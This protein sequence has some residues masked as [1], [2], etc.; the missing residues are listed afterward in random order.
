MSSAFDDLLFSFRVNP[1]ASD[2][3]D[4]DFDEFMQKRLAEFMSIRDKYDEYY[5]DHGSQPPIRMLH[6]SEALSVLESVTSGDGGDHSGEASESARLLAAKLRIIDPGL[7]RDVP[8]NIPM[9]MASSFDDTFA[10][11]S[12]ALVHDL[13]AVH[14]ALYS[15]KST[16]YSHG[17][18]SRLYG[19]ATPYSDTESVTERYIYREWKTRSPWIQLM[20]DL[21]LHYRLRNGLSEDTATKTDAPID[22][23]PLR[24][25]HLPQVHE[26]LRITFWPGIDGELIR[27]IDNGTCFVK[28]E[29][30]S[31][32]TADP[33]GSTIVA[34][35][36]R[37]V[38]GVAL[39]TPPPDEAYIPYVAVRVGWER[40]SIGITMLFHLMTANK[41]R[42]IIL[43]VSANNP[44]LILYN[45]LGF[46]SEEFIVGFY[47]DYLDPKSK[48]CRNALRLRL[49]QYAS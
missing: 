28:S 15:L 46:K 10:A 37:I 17:F 20:E 12:E 22:Y 34:V 43:H 18:A 6:P 40:C 29:Q 25:E 41:D 4:D 1:H 38:V 5:Q 21:K 36:K 19:F 7:P 39:I 45:K 26:L 2:G 11:A 44:A 33:P 24:S 48:A 9:Q 27:E 8:K 31:Q 42:D 3:S 23:V 30:V 47:E 49:R 14:T 13:S 16:P 35:Y 32:A